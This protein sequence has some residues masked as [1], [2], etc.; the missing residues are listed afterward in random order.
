[1][2]SGWM[3]RVFDHHRCGLNSGVTLELCTDE[4]GIEGP[5]ILGIG[6]CMN[7]Y[8]GTTRSEPVF[9]GALFGLAQDVP[10]GTQKH[11]TGNIRQP[12]GIEG[13]W[14]LRVMEGP[15]LLFG[16][17]D[18]ERDAILNGAMPKPRGMRKQRARGRERLDACSANPRG[19]P[20]SA[21]AVYA[22]A[23]CAGQ[24]GPAAI[25]WASTGR[26]VAARARLTPRSLRASTRTPS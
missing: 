1:M 5:L 17:R 23:P 25:G 18:E 8:K 16:H 22:S 9:E 3:G 26:V 15:T 20:A 7:S 21:A 4:V 11:Y 14:V 6:R 12:E 2:G 13:R 10:S 19:P 24:V